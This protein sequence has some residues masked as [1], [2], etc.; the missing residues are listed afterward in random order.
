MDEIQYS[1][2]DVN[3]ILDDVAYCLGELGFSKKQ[4]RDMFAER[5]K[6]D[7]E[8]VEVW[9]MGYSNDEKFGF[10]RIF[11]RLPENPGEGQAV[12]VAQEDLRPMPEL[13]DYIKDV[14][15]LGEVKDIGDLKW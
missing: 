6:D 1:Q 14:N 9:L 4:V 12:E 11:N 5:F 7:T 15:D 10:D 2:E 3:R 13:F 8:Y